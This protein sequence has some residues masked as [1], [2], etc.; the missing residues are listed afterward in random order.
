MIS[1]SVSPSAVARKR[2]LM[3]DKVPPGYKL[4][5]R[6]WTTTK[7]GRVIWAKWCGKKAFPILVPVGK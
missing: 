4:I 5:Y 3:S 6:A 2:T 1:V 7:N